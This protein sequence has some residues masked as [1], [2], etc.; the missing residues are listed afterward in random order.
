MQVKSMLR[1][2]LVYSMVLVHA[3][4]AWDILQATHEDT[5]AMKVSEF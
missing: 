1:L 4:E 2:F 5:Y 3:K